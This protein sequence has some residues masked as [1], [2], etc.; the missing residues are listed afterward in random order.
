MFALLVKWTFL[1]CLVLLPVACWQ[2]DAL[3]ADLDLVA[4]LAR[5][6]DQSEVREAPF[7]VEQG[8]VRYRVEPLYRYRLQGLVVSRRAHDGDSMLHGRWN[9][10][11]NVADV[12]VV[13][14]HN[15]GIDLQAFEFWSG[16]FTCF[17]RTDDPAAW[18]SFDLTRMAN[19]HLLSD[20]DYLRERIAAVRVGDQI[21][22]EGYLARYSNDSGFERGTSVTR[23]DTG[24]GACETVYVTRF[25]VLRDSPS[26][27]P[28]L[29]STAG[30]GLL[31]SVL[32]WVIGA[33]R[34]WL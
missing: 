13:W 10:H 28:A 24:N 9:D 30:F 33:L 34:G 23:T 19:N 8:G 15:T 27:W 21:E 2:A 5:D 7:D 18:R 16:Q 20:D 11:L 6:P 12:C 32:L 29:Q 14:G 3:P 26:V 31:G 25:R 17:F 22:F 4:D 1:G